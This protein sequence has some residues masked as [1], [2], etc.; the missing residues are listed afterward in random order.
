MARTRGISLAATCGAAVLIL[1]AARGTAQDRLPGTPPPTFRTGVNLVLVDMRVM[2]GDDQVTDLSAD[3]LTLLVD[4]RPRPIVSLDYFSARTDD[5]TAV[6]DGGPAARSAAVRRVVLV[7]DRES[8]DAAGAQKVLDAAM[9]FVEKAPPDYAFAVVTLPLGADI[10]F[11]EDRSM[12]GTTLAGALS[13]SERK[14]PGLEGIAG[15]GCTGEAASRGCGTRGLP[16]EIEHQMARSMITGSEWQF[17]GSNVLRDLQ[18]LFRT[19]AAEPTD[20]VLLTGGLPR[21]ERLRPEVDRTLEIARRSRARVHSVTVGDLSRVVLTQG[22]TPEIATLET[23]RTERHPTYDLPSETGGIEH[24]GS[25]S[26]GGFFKRLARELAGT[27]LLTFE[28]LASE[29]DDRAHEIVVRVSRRPQPTVHARKSFVLAA[30]RSPAMPDTAVASAD[31]GPADPAAPGSG[32]APVPTMTAADVSGGATTAAVASTAP[33]GSGLRGI[34]RRASAYVD[35]FERTLSSLVAEERYVQIMKRWEGQSPAPAAAPELDWKAG[36][37]TPR[38]ADRSLR[39]RQ[40]L[41]DVLLVQPPGRRWVAFRDVAEVDGKPV[42]DRAVRVEKLFLSDSTDARRQL[43]KIVDESAR[44]NLGS[45]RN[46]NVPTFPLLILRPQNLAR[47]EWTKGIRKRSPAD[48]AACTV[49]GFRETAVPTIVK[50]DSGRDVPMSGTLCVEPGTGRV[51]RATIE[52][53]ERVE[54]VR[55]AFEVRFRPSEDGSV[56]VPARAWEWHLSD[57]PGRSDR[58]AY[59][60]GQATYSNLRRFT[61]ST[62]E[63]LR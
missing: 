21:D 35:A 51:W 23:V 28:P 38:G 43:Q 62:Q 2:R 40:L 7:V 18:A 48:P 22:G 39:R 20:I 50:T 44:H 54:H 46:I 42:R 41:S 6:A 10:R 27:Y 52:F 25:G 3:D 13:G 19:V 17:R 55:G 31:P 32:E 29:R 47:F 33:E 9:A 26:A 63:Q 36:G 8:I 24:S 15:F 59:V 16:Y 60:E 30:Q 4:G 11:E 12:V 14:G 49:V 1:A 53:H 56:L 34:L 57:G 5:R 58:L 45:S 61:V 37:E